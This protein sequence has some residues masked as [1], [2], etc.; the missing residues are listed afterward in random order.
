MHV[1]KDVHTKL[2]LGHAW[3]DVLG[4]MKRMLAEQRYLS[5]A[6]HQTIVHKS[7]L[8]FKDASR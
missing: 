2:L 8:S 3:N 1:E 4:N 5:R 7:P 6:P